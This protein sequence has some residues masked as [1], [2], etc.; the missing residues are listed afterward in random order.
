MVFTVD[1]LFFVSEIN[2]PFFLI[3]ETIHSRSCHPHLLQGLYRDGETSNVNYL[4]MQRN[5]K[6]V[7]DKVEDMDVDNQSDNEGVC[8]EKKD[9]TETSSSSSSTSNTSGLVKAKSCKN[10]TGDKN[11]IVG[12]NRS[13]KLFYQ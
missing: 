4:R 8:L 12:Q 3:L 2:Q 10:N 11:C 5:E 7:L 9:V 6:S 1:Q 13:K